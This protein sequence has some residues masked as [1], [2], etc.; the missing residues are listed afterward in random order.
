MLHVKRS[1]YESESKDEPIGV[2]SL[3]LIWE[4]GDRD[5]ELTRI[6]QQVLEEL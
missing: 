2:P 3:G 5:Q 4:G 1:V 6:L